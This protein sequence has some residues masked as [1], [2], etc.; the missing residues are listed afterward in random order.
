MYQPNK[1]LGLRTIPNAVAKAP[2]RGI[3]LWKWWLQRSLWQHSSRFFL[4][5]PRLLETLSTIVFSQRGVFRDNKWQ[6]KRFRRHLV[7]RPSTVG[8]PG[9]PWYFVLRR[10]ADNSSSPAKSPCICTGICVC[11]RNW[12]RIRAENRS[13]CSQ[14]RVHFHRKLCRPVRCYCRVPG[15]NR[16]TGIRFPARPTEIWVYRC[17]LYS[18]PVSSIMSPSRISL[19]LSLSRNY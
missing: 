14:L 4:S 17:S 16:A 2:D 8:C 18:I 5:L 15:Q 6:W 1:S 11:A 12:A 10:P 13:D 19:L 7:S 9:I 3:T